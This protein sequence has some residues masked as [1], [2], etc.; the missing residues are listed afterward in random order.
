M[1]EK[2]TKSL[3]IDW[4]RKKPLKKQGQRKMSTKNEREWIE[5]RIKEKESSSK[6]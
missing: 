6:N 3:K 1:K 5:E 2:E 4:E